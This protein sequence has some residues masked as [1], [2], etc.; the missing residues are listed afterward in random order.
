METLHSLA[1]ELN[2]TLQRDYPLALSLLSE[3]GR[4]IYFPR[5]GILGQTTEALGTTFNATIGIALEDDGS[6]LHHAFFDQR[7]HASP[8]QIHPYA[9]SPGITEFR[10]LW[11]K[12]IRRKNPFI[13]FDLSLPVVTCGLTHALSTALLLFV[14]PE[15]EVIIT[16]F[17]WDNC[18]LII[19]EYLGAELKPFRMLAGDGWDL[20]SFR[21]ALRGEKPGNRVA[22]LN[23][24]NN[25]TGYSPTVA[26]A[27]Q[28]ADVLI[29]EAQRGSFITVILDDAYFGFGHEADVYPESL[30]ALLGDAHESI[31]VA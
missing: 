5:T 17:H 13:D 9:P 12:E 30:I 25:P 29:A 26:E 20:E 11:R 28:I 22:L 21:S 31:L 16:D 8:G 23:V 6:P 27:K 2:A 7:I 15:E 1:K 4:R 10:E 14:D 18:D 24:P 19:R 3:R